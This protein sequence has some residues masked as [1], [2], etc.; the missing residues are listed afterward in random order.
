MPPFWFLFVSVL[1]SERFAPHIQKAIAVPGGDSNFLKSVFGARR[2]DRVR[3]G[4][5]RGWKYPARTAGRGK[6]LP[7]SPAFFAYGSEKAKAARGSNSAAFL[8]IAQWYRSV[9]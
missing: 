8:S 3:A 2:A 4:N 5:S 7:G 9:F 1:L 6:I